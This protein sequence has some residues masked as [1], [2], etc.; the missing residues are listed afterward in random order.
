[1]TSKIFLYNDTNTLDQDIIE[2]E[3]ETQKINEKH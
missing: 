2:I 3:N 1:M